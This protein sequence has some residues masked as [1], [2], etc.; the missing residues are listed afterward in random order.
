M[1]LSKVMHFKLTINNKIFIQ[2]EILYIQRIVLK[3]RSK[4]YAMYILFEKAVLESGWSFPII[5]YNK[6]M[7][8]SNKKSQW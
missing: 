6:S 5:L 7:M 1:C 2:P 4:L 3:Y 8:M